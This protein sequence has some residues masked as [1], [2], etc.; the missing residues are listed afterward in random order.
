[1]GFTGGIEQILGWKGGTGEGGRRAEWN[2]RWIMESGA[3]MFLT[4][5][6][7]QI[8]LPLIHNVCLLGH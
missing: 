7:I 8:I 6:Y 4:S 3:T 1:M 5:I 2:R